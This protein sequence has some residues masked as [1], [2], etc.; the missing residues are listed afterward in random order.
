[1]T[2]K[3][4]SQNVLFCLTAEKA[5]VVEK[6]YYE[7]DAKKFYDDQLRPFGRIVQR[8]G[9]CLYLQY[10]VMGNHCLSVCIHLDTH[11]QGQ[12]FPYERTEGGVKYKPISALSS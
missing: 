6:I 4:K 5:I 7:N 1:M 10:H 9:D 12:T 2:V 3:W 8:F 11:I